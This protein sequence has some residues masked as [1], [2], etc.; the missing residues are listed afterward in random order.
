MTS[1][2]IENIERRTELKRKTA[3]PLLWVGLVSIIMFFMG[4]TSAV[5]V[6]KGGDGNWLNIQIPFAF[7]ISTIIIVVSSF[8][9]H[10]GFISIKKDNVQTLKIS[11]LVTLFLG[12]LFIYSQFLG[13]KELYSNGI[14]AT[15]ASSSNAS[16]YLY[17]ITF[18]HVLHLIAGVISL[19]VVFIKSVK[20]K[21][22]STNYLGVEVSIIYWHFLG[23]LWI[24]LFFFLKYIA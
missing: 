24:Y 4:W 15:G 6:S 12:V 3:K 8:V 16:S 17:L 18:F 1:I 11:S 13:W 22:S 20:Q 21:Y 7:T 2:S 5:I 19:I 23:G 9:Y 14:V 10:Y